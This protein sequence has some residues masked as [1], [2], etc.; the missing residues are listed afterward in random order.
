MD[1]WIF[2]NPH[3]GLHKNGS[4]PRIY[5]DRSQP[6]RDKSLAEHFRPYR[7]SH[8]SVALTLAMCRFPGQDHAS[9]TG[10]SDGRLLVWKGPIMSQVVEVSQRGPVVSVA[11]NRSGSALLTAVRSVQK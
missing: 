10:T 1:P 6:N 7:R 4:D 9:Y 2:K 5:S 11:V 8:Q 3:F